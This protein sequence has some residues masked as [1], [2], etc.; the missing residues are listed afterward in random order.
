MKPSFSLIFF[1]VLSGA[2]FGLF[3]LLVLVNGLS[4]GPAM[5]VAEVLTAG[6]LALVVAAVGLVSSTFHLANPK[7]GIK[8]F[9]RILTSWLS[10]EAALALL[11]YPFAL[12]YLLGVWVTGNDPGFWTHAAGV[13]VLVLG[14]ATVLCTGMIYASLKTIRQW[15]NP[16][17][18]V[19]YVLI[20]LASGGVLLSAVRM[21][22]QDATS[23]VLP[24]TL[25][26]LVAA[27][28]VKVVYYFWIGRPEGATINT[29]TSL[30]GR[31]VRLL[32]VGHTH[33][34][35][36]TDEFSNRIGPRTS[37]VLRT[38]ALAVGFLAPFL[39]LLVAPDSGAPAAHAVAAVAA[40]FAGILLERWLFLIE[41]QHVVNLYHGRQH[42]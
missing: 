30:T 4:L 39:I 13:L 41:G 38:T 8:A 27:A 5:P 7:N 22:A 35:F 32:D 23:A 42:T 6:I 16:L 33:G 36:L 28:F 12:L 15:H 11:L 20:G 31:S 37:T 1:S 18:P 2:G 3:M 10:R 26:L 24:L 14:L 17:V 29:A 19:S 40:A 9:N 34:T 25:G 21:L